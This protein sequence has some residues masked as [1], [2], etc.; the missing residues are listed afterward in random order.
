MHQN[1]FISKINSLFSWITK[2]AYVNLLWIIF[3]ILGFIIVGFFPATVAMMN[4]CRKW[5]SGDCDL[6]IYQTFMKTYKSELLR[7]NLLG[8]ALAG[9]GLLLYMNFLVLQAKP[10][11]ASIV[12]ISAFYLFVFFYIIT[13]TH[14][15]PIFVHYQVSFLTCIRNAF[16]MGLLNMHIS[17]AIVISQSAFFYLMFSYPASTVFFLGSILSMIQMWLAIRS[18]KRIDQKASIKK[19]AKAVA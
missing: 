17:L 6:P 9:I 4:I 11:G 1:G 3:S 15:L 19:Q 7:S 13:V 8:G 5:L 12:F 18:F 16:I 2:L 14:V 10:S